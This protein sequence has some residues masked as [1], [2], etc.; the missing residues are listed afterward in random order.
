MQAKQFAGIGVF[1][2]SFG[3]RLL[4]LQQVVAH[5][6]Y[7]D[8]PTLDSLVYVEWAK[9]IAGGEWLGVESF[10][11]S[12]LYGY[13]LGV[14]FAIGG[15][16]H[17]TPLLANAIFGSLTCV[18]IWALACR[19][20]D[21]RVA[22][23]AAALACF[24]RME[25]FYESAP[26]VE[27]MQTFLCAAWLWAAVT[28]LESPSAARFALAGA[29]LG[30]SVLARQNVLMFAAPFLIW[31]WLALRG[32]ESLAQR[33]RLA[34][35]YL[36]TLAL[37]ILPATLHNWVATRELVLV[38]SSGGIV[39]YIG[40]NREANGVF[41]VPSSLPRA[42]ADDPFEQQTAYR[43]LAEQRLGRKG[44][45]ASE[46][47][48]YWRSE[49][50]SWVSANPGAALSLGLEKAHLF[51]NAFEAWDVRSVSLAAATSWIM[52]LPLVSFAL[53]APLALAGIALSASRWRV[54]VP[55]YLALFLQFATAVLFLALSRYRLPA[56]PALAVFAGVT[57]VGLFDA[58]RA[59]DTRRL[60]LGG[61][62][63][64]L[65]ALVVHF[66]VPVENLAMAHFNLGTAYHGRGDLEHARAEFLESLREA[67]NYVSAWNDLALVYEQ[68]RADLALQRDAW[69]HVLDL[70][71]AQG[72]DR[73]TERAARHLAA[74]DR[75][76]LESSARVGVT[77]R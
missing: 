49:A 22:L 15:P 23:V 44:L 36:A 75:S 6:P 14:M 38:N 55:L 60:A 10:Y 69:R 71:R 33:A 9:K 76:D 50:W 30:L 2:T 11:A 18:L 35:A 51:W 8:Q 52:R 64:A 7:Y 77:P 29:A 73:H 31:A 21:A 37:C 28:A 70:G 58:L 66:R 47:S 13:L 48:S 17:W 40:W 41:M 65:A 45:A 20:F 67:P 32:R 56:M 74:L 54:L 39:L 34:S 43:A 19:L 24:Y 4:H 12:P 68:S 72:S 27:A 42:L 62:S 26:L 16:S 57:P 63:L 5:D 25:I 3:V 61:A 46:V 53:L 1:A 59:R